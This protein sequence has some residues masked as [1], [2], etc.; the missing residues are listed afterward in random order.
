MFKLVT[1]GWANLD[2]QGHHMNK[3]GR[4]QQG[5]AAYQISK[6]YAFQFQRR[7]ILKMLKMGFF[8]SMFQLPPPPPPPNLTPGI[9]YEQTW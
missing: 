3:L 8:I 2:P 5:D 7:R 4:D 9:S 6:L 1:P